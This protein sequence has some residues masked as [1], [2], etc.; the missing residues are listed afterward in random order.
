MNLIDLLATAIAEG[1]ETVPEG[2]DIFET[3]VKQAGRSDSR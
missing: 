3:A 1:D 2:P